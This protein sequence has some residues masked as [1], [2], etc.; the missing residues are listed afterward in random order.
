MATLK[1]KLLQLIELFSEDPSAEAELIHREYGS[2]TIL[3]R[4]HPQYAESH[5]L[6]VTYFLSQVIGPLQDKVWRVI[7]DILEI[8]RAAP[9]SE[10]YTAGTGENCELTITYPLDITDSAGFVQIVISIHGKE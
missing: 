9:H 1:A 10:M 4:E 2:I 5:S 3:H 6:A 8:S 7:E